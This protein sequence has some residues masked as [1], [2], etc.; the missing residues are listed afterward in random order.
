MARLRLDSFGVDHLLTRNEIILV[1]EGNS[2][3][4]G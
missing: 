3:H 4:L 1:F 2:L